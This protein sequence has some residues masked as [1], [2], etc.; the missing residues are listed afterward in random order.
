MPNPLP[1]YTLL[2]RN[3]K[4]SQLTINEMDGNLLWLA[5]TLSGSITITGSVNADSPI[6]APQFIGTS[7][8]ASY[9]LTASYIDPITSYDSSPLTVTV[10]TTAILPNNPVY[11]NGSLG[12]GAFISGSING[13]LGNI[14]SISVVA[15]DR[16][17]IKNQTGSLLIAN[18]IYDITSTGSASS[19]Y[20]LTRTTDSDTSLELDQQI[21]VPSTGS[22]NVGKLFSQQT[23]TPVI[24]TDSITYSLITYT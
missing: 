18:G 24:G 12:V 22:V 5:Q 14:D 7:S 1:P 3:V 6:T 21:V 10:A 13:T 11:D 9:A 23:D 16:I 17:L 19:R 4:G 8:Y 2:T 15:G 20:I